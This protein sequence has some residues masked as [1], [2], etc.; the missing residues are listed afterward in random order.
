MPSVYILSI[1]CALSVCV[2]NQY[3]GRDRVVNLRQLFVIIKP[4]QLLQRHPKQGLA[5]RLSLVWCHKYTVL[6]GR[7]GRW[8]DVFLPRPVIGLGSTGA[9]TS[10]G[11]RSVFVLQGRAGDLSS[12]RGEQTLS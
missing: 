7:G 2:I 3:T 9:A 8:A 4:D 1:F 10:R 5:Q 11:D 12:H 6:P